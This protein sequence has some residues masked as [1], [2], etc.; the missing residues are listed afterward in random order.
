MNEIEEEASGEDPVLLAQAG[1]DA[2]STGTTLTS[3]PTDVLV[4]TLSLFL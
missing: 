1:E 2:E 4:R 3:L